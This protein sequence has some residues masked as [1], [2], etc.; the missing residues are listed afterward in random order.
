[1]PVFDQREQTVHIQY[2]L[3]FDSSNKESVETLV[4][5]LAQLKST[6]PEMPLDTDAKAELMAE[7]QTVETQLASPK[8]KSRI[9]QESL[10]TIRSIL[11]GIVGN[12]AYAGLLLGIN[13][14]LS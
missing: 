10:Q 5:L 4:T 8:P 9:L 11:E 1:M 3:N 13:R 14:L 7:V 2:N 12:A 6:L